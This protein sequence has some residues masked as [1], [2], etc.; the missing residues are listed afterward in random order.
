MDPAYVP[1]TTRTSPTV[2]R[3][4]RNQSR[5]VV[6]DVVTPSQSDEEDTQISSSD[7]STFGPKSASAS[8]FGFGS[9]SGS[10]SPGMT[11]SSDEITSAED[12]PV[13]PNTV[14]APVAEEPNKWCVDGQWQIYRDSRMINEKEQMA[15]LIIEDR[16][17]LTG[18]FH[19][20][21]NI[22]ALFQRHRCEWMAR[23]PGSY[24]EEIVREFYASYVATLRR[25]IEKWV[26]PAAQPP[27]KATLVHG[28]SVDISEATI[29]RFL[30]DPSHTLAI[31]MVKFGY[32]WDIDK[33]RKVLEKCKNWRDKGAANESL[34]S[35]ATP[36]QTVVGLKT[37]SI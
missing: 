14:P 37:Q 19:T 8:G 4:T 31:N 28:F 24:S 26:K 1:P 27:L 32:R 30:Y 20:M 29:N 11:A 9:A 22:Q 13:P 21:P 5:Q 12:I 16:R 17:A 7:G 6:P 15:R 33:E 18:N 10:S 3:T 2:P 23:S 34:K 25:S 35:S 36:T